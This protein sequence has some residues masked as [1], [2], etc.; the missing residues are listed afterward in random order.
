MDM[1]STPFTVTGESLRLID[2]SSLAALL[3]V[4]KSWI[5]EQVR[6][7]KMTP[8]RLGRQLRFRV[9]DI[10]KYL[11]EHSLAKDP[12]VTRDSA[13]A[14]TTRPGAEGR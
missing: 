13:S 12:V 11:D 10:E 6:T 9:V 8:I 3:G 1:P 5:Y 7:G 4:K 2:V 14:L